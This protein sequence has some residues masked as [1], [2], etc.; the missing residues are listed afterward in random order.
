MEILLNSLEIEECEKAF[1]SLKYNPVI[2]A[3]SL[4]LSHDQDDRLN[5]ETSIYKYLLEYFSG[6]IIPLRN[7]EAKLNPNSELER[8][9]LLY[10]L[11]SEELFNFFSELDVAIYIKSRRAFSIALRL[12]LQKIIDL[13]R[14]INGRKWI[15]D[16]NS[17]NVQLNPNPNSL[18][19]AKD[20]TAKEIQGNFYIHAGTNNWNRVWLHQASADER[21]SR[22]LSVWQKQL[23]K[24]ENIMISL[25]RVDYIVLIIPEKD[26]LARISNDDFIDSSPIPYLYVGELSRLV[27]KNKF[28]FPVYELLNNVDFLKFSEPESHL[29]PMQYWDI[30]LLIIKKWGFYDLIKD[31]VPEIIENKNFGDLTLKFKSL[32]SNVASS[33]GMQL[34]ADLNPTIFSGSIEFKTPLRDSYVSF[35]NDNAPLKHSVL[36]L[37]D[38]HSSLGKLPFLTG[39]FSYFFS[40]V[41]F[42]WNPCFLESQDFDKESYDF[43][44]SEISQRFVMPNLAINKQ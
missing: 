24:A 26:T 28:L 22:Q 40:S 38:S 21:W 36:I 43:C 30:F 19:L 41:S 35:I 32:N 13:F 7:V 4:L 15:Y 9:D 39:I 29:M 10:R 14:E 34:N 33:S 6:E 27:D 25:K 11:G 16:F 31:I 1:S 2:N 17:L 12:N 23:A 20:L 37:G 5:N 3:K 42:Y 44:V 8:L 18:R